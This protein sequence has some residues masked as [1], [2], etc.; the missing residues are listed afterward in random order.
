[1][2][3]TEQ[4]KKETWF[5]KNIVAPHNVHMEISTGS[6]KQGDAFS[7]TSRLQY[8]NKVYHVSTSALKDVIR[9]KS[10]DIARI[11]RRL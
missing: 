6:L 3:M 1:M 2:I 7:S 4:C 5:H 9:N 10:E 11:E 8:T